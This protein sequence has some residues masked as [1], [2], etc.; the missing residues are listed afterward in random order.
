MNAIFLLKYSG[1]K[2]F[3]QVFIARQSSKWSTL[4]ISYANSAPSVM[5]VYGHVVGMNP[6]VM[7][8]VSSKAYVPYAA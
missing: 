1:T 8:I 5:T 6:D 4:D 2:G 7:K 3:R